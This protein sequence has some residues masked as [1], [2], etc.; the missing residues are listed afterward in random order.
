MSSVFYK[1]M[2][3]LLSILPRKWNNEDTQGAVG[4]VI[5]ISLMIAGALFL[6]TGCAFT[7]TVEY[8]HHSSVPLI[9]DLNTA[10]QVGVCGSWALGTN[11]YAPWMEVCLHNELTSKPVFGDDPV[12]TIRL[13]QPLYQRD[14]R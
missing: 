9:R 14:N 13:K 2:S 8:E 6:L 1:I 11:K 5:L 4:G 10:D 12:G 3:L 7:A